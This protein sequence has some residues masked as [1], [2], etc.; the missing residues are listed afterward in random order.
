MSVEKDICTARLYI[1]DD[2][3]DNSA[4]IRCQLQ[5]G[6]EGLHREK[7]FRGPLQ[8]AVVVITWERDESLEGETLKMEL[9]NVNR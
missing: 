1:A 5:D 6:H 7:F 4:T 8:S 2:W 3:G 9:E